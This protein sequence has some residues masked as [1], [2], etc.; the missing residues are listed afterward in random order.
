M[1]IWYDADGN[2][3]EGEP[4]EG[5]GDDCSIGEVED[6]IT[7]SE[8]WSDPA[9]W[10]D[11]EQESDSPCGGCEGVHCIYCSG[12]DTGEEYFSQFDDEDDDDS[13]D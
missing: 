7:H 1:A 3:Q 13:E 10:E 9:A 12:P 2:E 5:F 4:P 11:E 8:A 6:G